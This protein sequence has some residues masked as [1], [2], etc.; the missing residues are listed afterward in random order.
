M[1]SVVRILQIFGNSALPH[2]RTSAILPWDPGYEELVAIWS[3][4]REGEMF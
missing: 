1:S 2:F 3:E 4:F